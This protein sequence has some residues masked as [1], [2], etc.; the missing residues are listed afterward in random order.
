MT[1]LGDTN[2]K[3]LK[4]VVEF[5]KIKSTI[6]AVPPPSSPR[7]CHSRSKNVNFGNRSPKLHT[8]AERLVYIVLSALH[9]KCGVLLFALLVYISGMLLYMG[10]LSLEVIAPAVVVKPAPL[11]S[12]PPIFPSNTDEC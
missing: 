1:T 6:G 12:L 5:H 9:R 10:S 8:F 3:Y 4:Q 2:Y 11:G 7:F